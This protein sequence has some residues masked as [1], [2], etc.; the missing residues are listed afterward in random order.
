MLTLD[1]AIQQRRSIRKFLIDDVPDGQIREMLES[2]RL[3]PS[4]GNTQPWRFLVV[5]DEKL[6]KEICRLRSNQKFI[7]EAPVTIVCFADLDRYSQA[8]RKNK[9]RDLVEWEIAP[10]LSGD[11]AKEEHWEQSAQR[12]PSREQMVFQAVSN[13]FIAI[14]HLLLKATTLGLG[15]C[16]LGAV[17]IPSYNKLFALP[18]NLVI[19]G[20]VVVGHSAGKIPPQR[21]RISMEQM[22]LSPLAQST[23]NRTSN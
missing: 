4:G 5:R 22:L 19:A 15:T 2:A 1:E 12:Q 9:W 14:E 11:L 17:D 18:D 23:G 8:A 16:W 21:P 6:R 7:E 20:I 3:A 10:T 13:T